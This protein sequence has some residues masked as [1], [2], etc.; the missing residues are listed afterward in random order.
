MPITIPV[1]DLQ[2]DFSLALAEIRRLYL[3]DALRDTVRA[4]DIAA[5]DQQIGRLVPPL[6]LR[7]G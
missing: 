4:L 3:Q 2:I 7:A 5:L 1:P 6:S